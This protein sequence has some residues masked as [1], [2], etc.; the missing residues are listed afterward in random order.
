MDSDYTI[1]WT[2]EAINNLESIL[3]YLQNR[4]TQKE[5]ISSKENLANRSNYLKKIPYY[6]RFQ[7][8]TT[9]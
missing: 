1:F 2:E 7:S 3:D 6:S 9:D 8:I 4:W 5:L